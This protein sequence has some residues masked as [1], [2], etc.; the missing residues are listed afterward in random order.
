M[1]RLLFYAWTYVESGFRRTK[2][3]ILNL[4]DDPVVVLAYHRVTDP[5]NDFHML[6]VSPDNFRAHMEY[7][8]KNC[9]VIRFEEDW[10]TAKKPAVAVTF[11]DGYADNV[12]N[13]LAIIEE[14]GVPATF[15]ISTDNI[16]SGNEFWWDELERL[17]LGESSYPQ[18]FQL[19]DP[20]YGKTWPT[21]SYRD[22]RNMYW[23]L[24]QSAKRINAEQRSGWLRQIREWAG[25]NDVVNEENR[26][27]T[28]DELTALANSQWVTIG[29]HTVTHPP[30]AFLTETEQLHEIVSSMQ[31]LEKFTG[32]KISVFSYPFGGKKDYDRT[33]VRI[34]REAGITKAAAAFPGE[35][36]RWSD[37]YQIPRHSIP[38]WDLETFDAALKGFGIR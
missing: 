12:R 10:S 29:A 6:K 5:Q 9:N 21:A 36:H 35:A 20:T 7:L 33:T 1:S 30:L 28:Y 8:K 17:V 15:F 34:C 25:L 11:D 22:R 27:L 31:L 19:N 2:N 26:S 16:G 23:D 37:P 24:H 32:R 13:A 3:R 4:I 14:V 38:N 18:N